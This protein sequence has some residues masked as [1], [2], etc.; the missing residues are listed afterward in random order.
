M[1]MRI[2]TF[3]EPGL[4]DFLVRFVQDRDRLLEETL[5]NLKANQSLLLQ[6]PAGKVYEVKVNDAGAL[7]ITQVAG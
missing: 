5:S 1:A 6:S 4:S 3:K 7:T 2:P